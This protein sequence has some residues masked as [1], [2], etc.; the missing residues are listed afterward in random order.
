[1]WI[2]AGAV[3]H[4]LGWDLFA[5]SLGES[6]RRGVGVIDP[7]TAMPELYVSDEDT[8]NIAQC[9][10]ELECIRQVRRSYACLRDGMNAA[11]V[12]SKDG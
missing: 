2:P 8:N 12:I 1:M 10:A 3:I 7:R 6:D 11:H 9:S 5:A 4:A